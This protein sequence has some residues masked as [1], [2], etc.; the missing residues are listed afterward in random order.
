MHHQQVAGFGARI[1]HGLAV[2]GPNGAQVDQFHRNALRR[3]GLASG[4][5]GEQLA[6]PAHQG[7][8]FAHPLHRCF[9]QGNAQ[10]HIHR[11]G[12]APQGFVLHVND[13]VA[14]LQGRAQQAVVVLGVAGAHHHQAGQMGK[15]GLQGLRVLRRRGVPNAHGHARHQGHP[16][17]A[18]KHIAVFGR[19]VDDFVHG[20]Q[21]KVD[22]PHFHHGAQ[23]GQGHA[24]AAA[25]DGGFT[26]GGVDHPLRAKLGLQ[27]LVLAK[28]AAAPDVFA[29]HHHPGVG[30]H[31]QRQGLHGRFA[32]T[33]LGQ[34]V[35]YHWPSP[36]VWMSVKAPAGSGQGAASAVCMAS[37]TSALAAASIASSSAL[38]PPMAK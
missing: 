19:L 8:L 12:L 38:L 22:H 6:A 35:Q 23:T 14:T 36:V 18:T 27:A 13:R 31:F 24:H 3:Q 37:A 29:H 11:T 21:G 25:H 2:P 1:Q 5:A 15:P 28:N 7:D 17:L 9:A 10:V 20:A 33:P 30:L 32:V 26:D 4:L 16:A 34:G